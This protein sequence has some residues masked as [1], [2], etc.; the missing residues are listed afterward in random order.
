MPIELAFHGPAREGNDY[1][2]PTM[3]PIGD[4]PYYAILI[5]GG[6]LDTKGGP[7]VNTKAQMLLTTGDPVP[8]L[9][10]AGNC[11]ASPAGQAYWAGGGTIG[12]ALVFGYMAAMQATKETAKDA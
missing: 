5:G 11:I 4:G 3:Y 2:N 8:G 10:G 12:P 1:P 9:Y 6:T 7:K